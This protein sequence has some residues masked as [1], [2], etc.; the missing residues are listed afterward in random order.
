M[1]N[2]RREAFVCDPCLLKPRTAALGEPV[3]RDRMDV[4]CER[5][6]QRS[7]EGAANVERVFPTPIAP[8]KVTPKKPAETAA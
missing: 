2:G 7:A 5:R 3:S 8:G 1:R 4:A 6:G